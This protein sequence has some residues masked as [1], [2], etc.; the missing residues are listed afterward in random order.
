MFKTDQRERWGLRAPQFRSLNRRKS[1]GH[2]L[3]R[4]ISPPM[5]FSPQAV[6]G[7]SSCARVL[8]TLD[9]QLAK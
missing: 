7:G 6:I 3:F 8:R 1:Y 9:P 5:R 4:L 2:C